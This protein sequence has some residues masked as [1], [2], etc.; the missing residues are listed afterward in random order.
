ME[1]QIAC[2]SVIKH[3][4]F[5]CDKT[6]EKKEVNL[7]DREINNSRTFDPKDRSA[8]LSLICLYEEMS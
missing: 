1:I 2:K 3:D 7:S 5:Q 6:A 4:P 8:G